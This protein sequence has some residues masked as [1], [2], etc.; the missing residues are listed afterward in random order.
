MHDLLNPNQSGFRSGDS[1]VHQLIAITHDIYKSFDSNPSLETR[2]LFLDISKAFDRVWHEGLLFK[3]KRCGINGN[4]FSLIKSFLSKRYQRVVLNG[5]LSNWLPVK[6]GVPQGSILGP[7]FFLI[8]INDLSEGL[9]SNA[10]LFAD[11]T[12]LFSTVHS[13]INTG[14]ELNND[15]KTISRWAY[16]WKMLFNPDLNKQAQ[17]VL[18]TRKI[19]KTN[20][21][22]LY[23]NNSS[24][25]QFPVQKHLGLYLDERL[26]FNY[27]INE[28]IKKASKSIGVLRNLQNILPRTSLLTIYKSFIRPLL[29]YGDVIY[30]QPQNES[31]CDKIESVQ[32]NAALA[33]TGA[34]RG[35]SKEKLYQELGL[36]HLRDRRRMRRLCLF[37]KI[38]TNKSPSYLFEIIPPKLHSARVANTFQTFPC[39]TEFYMNSF[40][41]Y[42][43]REWNKLDLKTRNCESFATFRKSILN[44]IRPSEN[45][46]FNIHRPNGVKLLTRLRLGFSHLREHK[47]RHNFEDTLNPLC[48]CSIEPETTSH[49]FLHCHNYDAIRATLIN[50]LNPIN[51]TLHLLDDSELIQ[52]ILFGNAKFNTE[53][54]R[55]ILLASINYIIQSKRFD[56]PLF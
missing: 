14:N 56:K 21:P 6:A 22:T 37:Y 36:E 20:H 12:S 17:E 35:T 26:S 18:F 45:S 25:A 2:G 1:C 33:I 11:D 48:S 13:P 5:Q 50:E 10:K 7:L 3:L 28:Q 54:N 30:D 39:R 23:F 15:L 44:D 32:Y 9:V 41:P 4:L 38:I 43:V 55:R 46:L 49:Y 8:Y 40:F 52:I 31:L 42:T 19:K 27:H 47:F 16:Q 51:N 53:S 34:I 29:D 24:I